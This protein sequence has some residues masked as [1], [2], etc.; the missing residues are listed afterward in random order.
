MKNKIVVAILAVVALTACQKSEEELKKEAENRAQQQQQQAQA[1]EQIKPL[2][3]GEFKQCASEKGLSVAIGSTSKDA[4]G[5]TADVLRECGRAVDA[6]HSAAYP[7]ASSLIDQ[8]AA[9]EAISE[10][11][12]AAQKYKK[13]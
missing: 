12:A 1:A 2:V 5:L 13:V 4:A 9:K 8:A 6:L 10:I 3:L 11:I 7:N